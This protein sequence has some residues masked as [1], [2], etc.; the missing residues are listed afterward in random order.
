VTV[1]LAR[2]VLH[3][4]LSRGQAAGVALALVGV[5]MVSAGS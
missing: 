2:A 1:L 3:E 4:R 5:G